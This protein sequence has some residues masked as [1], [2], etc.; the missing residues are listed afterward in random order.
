[1]Q[2]V[3]RGLATTGQMVLPTSML[4]LYYK[5]N[6]VDEYCLLLRDTRSFYMN[7]SYKSIRL[8]MQKRYENDKNFLSKNIR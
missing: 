6:L 8:Q 1:M 2:L 4:R 7:K 5:T 3:S